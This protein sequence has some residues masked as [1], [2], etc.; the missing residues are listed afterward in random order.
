[1]IFFTDYMIQ[2]LTTQISQ[3]LAFV[4]N[5]A[6]LLHGCLAPECIFISSSGHWKLAGFE[7]SLSLGDSSELQVGPTL[8]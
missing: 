3:G 4:H 2:S 7:F 5:E 1:M 8:R 6:N